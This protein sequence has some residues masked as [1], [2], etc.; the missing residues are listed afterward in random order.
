MQ[1]PAIILQVLPCSCLL[2]V[3]SDLVLHPCIPASKHTDMCPLMAWLRRNALLPIFSSFRKFPLAHPSCSSLFKRRKHLL[4]SLSQLS[5]STPTLSPFYTM[6]F[7]MW[8]LQTSSWHPV[9]TTTTRLTVCPECLRCQVS[10]QYEFSC[11]IYML[12]PF[13][14][15]KKTRPGKT[16]LYRYIAFT[17]AFRASHLLGTLTWVC[18]LRHSPKEGLY[19]TAFAFEVLGLN[20]GRQAC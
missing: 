18:S 7:C 4:W 11:F 1:A 6:L 19:F 13:F 8:P 16:S 17:L 10:T 14:Q 15:V 5:L 3:A 9:P 12:P 2:G 20:P